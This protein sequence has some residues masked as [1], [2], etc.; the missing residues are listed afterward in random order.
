M[1]SVHPASSADNQL[2]FVFGQLRVDPRLKTRRLL[3]TPC[4]RDYRVVVN[5]THTRRPQK[6]HN[7][8]FNRSGGNVAR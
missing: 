4:R 3:V 1:K 2:A 5:Y 6:P 7:N 8:K